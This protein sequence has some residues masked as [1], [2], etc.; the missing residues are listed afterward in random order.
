[1]KFTV[2]RPTLL[3]AAKTA[4]ESAALDNKNH[5]ELTGLLLEADKV[6]FHFRI[7][8][9]GDHFLSGFHLALRRR[10][11]GFNFGFVIPAVI[12]FWFTHID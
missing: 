3:T 5:P 4:A 12:G 2:D 1:M 9:F 7:I 8:G 6:G 10:H 11:S